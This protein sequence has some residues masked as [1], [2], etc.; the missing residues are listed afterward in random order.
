MRA[1]CAVVELG[2]FARAADQ[3]DVSTTA[4]SRLVA[5]LEKHLAA[6]L[7]QRS[8]RRLNLTETGAAYFERCRQIVADVDEA[9]AEAAGSDASPRGVL[10]IN[11]PVSFG[12]RY[13][14]PLIPG[15]CARYPELRLEVSFSDQTVELV[16]GG[17][18]MAL[19]IGA[20][21][22]TNLVARPLCPV[23]LMCCASPDYIRRRG[24]P[25]TPEELRQHACLT[26]S[27]AAGGDTW[28]FVKN[29]R[30]V[31]V[32][33]KPSFRANSGDM[34]HLAVLAGQGIAVQPTFII[35]DALRSG[36]LVRLLADHDFSERRA[37]VVY[38]PGSRR[39]ARV[40]AFC[41]LLR[42]A[43]GAGVPPWDREL[44]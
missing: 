6:Q 16:E 15:F 11:L 14:A 35:G 22:K 42:D 36:E 21:L 24:T 13:I 43:F 33:I 7:L 37:W 30:E 12:L 26:Y 5:D 40:Q 10:R 23:R 32:Q 17:I 2:S 44:E 31:A 39:S 1:F 3:L 28:R 25:R 29:G 9:E 4:I 41:E 19:R 20:E 18:D 38:Q 34:I 27:Y 8:T